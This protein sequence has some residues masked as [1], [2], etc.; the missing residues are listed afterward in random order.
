MRAGRLSEKIDIYRVTRTINS[1]GDVI[2]AY[3]AWKTDVRCQVTHLGTPSAGAS[4]FSDDNQEVGEMKAE[5]LCR[6]ISDI[7]FDDVIIWNGG[8]FNLYSILPIGRR[9]GMRLRARRRDN[10]NLPITGHTETNPTI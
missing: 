4:E 3:A 7:R 1:F 8:H 6:W 10:G 5:F 9:E 2:D